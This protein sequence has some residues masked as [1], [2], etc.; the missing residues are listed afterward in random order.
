MTYVAPS[1]VTT[2]QTYTSAAHNVIVGDII[3]HETRIGSLT[4]P[5]IV[6]VR[7]ATTQSI[8]NATDT[9]ITWTIEDIDTDGCFTASSDTVTIQTDGV[10]LVT[11][12]MTFAANATGYRRMD[13]F[14]NPSN[15]SDYGNA[16]FSVQYPVSSG[17]D[18]S[19]L[20]GSS[21]Q[22]FT[23]GQTIKAAVAQT[24]GGA[25]NVGNATFP[26]VSHLSATWMGRT[27]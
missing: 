1:T 19:F 18:D 5:P 14:K 24:S 11:A 8:T 20:M 21:I 23:S 12:G 26:Y 3:D 13:V 16:I 9:F 17:T 2:L 7:R 27:S 6:R 4:V 10:Y 15:A 25:L 22:S